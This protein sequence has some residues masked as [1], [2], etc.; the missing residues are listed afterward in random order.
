MLINR[1]LQILRKTKH[2]KRHGE[3]VCALLKDY[4]TKRPKRKYCFTSG[5]SGVSSVTMGASKIKTQ[6]IR[7]E[8]DQRQFGCIGYPDV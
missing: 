3:A 6:G 5:K 7:R 1:M 2:A 4:P 8:N